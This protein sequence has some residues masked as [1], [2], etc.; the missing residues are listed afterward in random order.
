MLRLTLS[1]SLFALCASTALAQPADT[2]DQKLILVTVDGVRWEEVFRGPDPEL[3]A[4]DDYTSSKDQLRTDY[5]DQDDPAEALMPFLHQTLASQGVVIGNRDA[6]SC[7]QLSNSRV[8]SYPGYNEILT[9]K[10]DPRINSNAKIPNDNVTILEWLNQ[11][12]A[13]EG[14]VFAFGSWDVFPFIINEARSG[15]P[16]NAGFEP[17]EP[18]YNAR[19]ELLN[20]LQEQIPSPWGSVR[21]DAFT[22]HFA[23]ETL[24]AETP[25]AIYIAYGEPDDFAHNGDFDQYINATH[26]FDAYLQ[27]LWAFAQSHPDYAGKTTLVITT[28]HGRGEDPVDS[29]R[30]HGVDHEGA[31]AVWIAAIGPNIDPE[32]GG[33]YTLDQCAL[34]NQV[35]ATGLQALGYEV[36]DYNPEAGAPLSIFKD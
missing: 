2:D 29:W 11:M 28:D 6:G 23:M 32:A 12:P 4:H 30:S 22:H 19:I 16:V 14:D 15:V 10:A 25:D 7:A 26:R 8:F 20:T 1:A 34:T 18:V 9:G 3:S 27:E 36:G 21:L 5:L 33:Q 17:L 13:H 24:K 31:E 35:A